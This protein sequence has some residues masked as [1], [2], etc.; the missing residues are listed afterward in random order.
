MLPVVPIPRCPML[1]VHGL[2][3]VTSPAAYVEF[4][5]RPD[6][7]I[8]AALASV[9]TATIRAL[10]GQA[11]TRF[12]PA[13]AES[14]C[15]PLALSQSATS[16]Q[17]GYMLT[18][19]VRKTVQPDTRRGSCDIILMVCLLLPSGRWRPSIKGSKAPHRGGERTGRFEFA[20]VPQAPLLQG[21]CRRFDQEV[22]L[23][24][25]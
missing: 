21:E 4:P 12:D 17:R 18:C 11:A 16:A 14:G 5:L 25:F 24:A 19:V 9:L 8:A 6:R 20:G 15:T 1:P 23:R 22:S 2:D 7:G 13:V 10:S 3:T